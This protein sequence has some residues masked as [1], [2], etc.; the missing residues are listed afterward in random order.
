MSLQGFCHE[1]VCS[2]ASCCSK[3]CDE[4]S[5]G[6]AKPDSN[7]ILHPPLF[8]STAGAT[9]LELHLEAT[10]LPRPRRPLI[11]PPPLAWTKKCIRAVHEA[12]LNKAKDMNTLRAKKNHQVQ[13]EKTNVITLEQ[14]PHKDLHSPNPVRQ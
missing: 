9:D 6:P 4:N 12:S 7:E 8:Q 13:T 2:I 11:F 10:G 5:H 14:P 1:V 3:G